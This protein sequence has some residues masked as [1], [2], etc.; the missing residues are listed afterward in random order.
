MVV[1]DFESCG[2]F[3][4]LNFKFSFPVKGLA[5]GLVLISIYFINLRRTAHQNSFI[6]SCEFSFNFIS[7]KFGNRVEPNQFSY[8]S[9]S[10]QDIRFHFI[11]HLCCA[12]ACDST[13]A[14]S[15]ISGLVWV[16]ITVA[17]WKLDRL[18]NNIYTANVASA[19]CCFRCVVWFTFLVR[20]F[21]LIVD[22]AA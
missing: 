16:C 20:C 22:H 11:L 3:F 10:R 6:F 1:F 8:L 5:C 4:V 19:F 7:D 14:S 18:D 17:H 21:V 2:L 15:I 13:R 9:A 12:L